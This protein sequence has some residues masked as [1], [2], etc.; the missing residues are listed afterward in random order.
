MEDFPLTRVRAHAEALIDARPTAV[1]TVLADYTTHHPRIMP[2]PQFSNLEVETG[3]IGAG[4]VFHITLRTAGK[5]QRLHMQVAE[6]EPGHV[7]TETN[8]D[9]G[10]VTIFSATPGNDGKRTITQISSEWETVGGLRGLVDRFI[11]PLLISRIFKKQL[12]QLSQYMRSG[13]A[14]T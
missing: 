11:A 10:V 3:G 7:L 5:E 13:D 12:H 8:L 14:P 2:E 1:Y 9:T 6:P 4:T